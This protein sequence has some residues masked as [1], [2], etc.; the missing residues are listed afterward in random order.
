MDDINETTSQLKHN[1]DGDLLFVSIWDS[2]SGDWLGSFEGHSGAVTDLDVD[3]NSQYLI[4]SSNDS[5]MKIWDLNNGKELYTFNFTSQCRIVSWSSDMRF[6]VTAALKYISKKIL[7][8]KELTK[9]MKEVFTCCTDGTIRTIRI[10]RTIRV[11]DV[12]KHKEIKSV[13]FDMY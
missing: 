13:V 2:L 3:L 6:F 5:M 12:T 4:S 7:F 10:I 1:Q 11:F 8:W 9:S